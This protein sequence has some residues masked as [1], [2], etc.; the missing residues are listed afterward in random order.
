VA[1]IPDGAPGVLLWKEMQEKQPM[2]FNVPPDLEMLVQKRLATGSFENVEDVFRSALETL[3]AEESW[4]AEERDALDNMIDCALEQ[5]ATGK[6]YGP[7]EA[8]RKLAAM[9][10]LHLATLS[11]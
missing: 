6:V 9:R 7:D 8:L 11:Q 3:D 4:T 10:Q 2:Q 5:V 1:E